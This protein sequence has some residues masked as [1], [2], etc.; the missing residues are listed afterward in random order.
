VDDKIASEL[1][2]GCMILSYTQSFFVMMEVDSPG[3][4]SLLL[5]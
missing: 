4:H 3:P 1:Y 2:F 5:Y